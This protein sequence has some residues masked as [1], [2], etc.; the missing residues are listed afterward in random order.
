MRQHRCRHILSEVALSTRNE[1]LFLFLVKS[2]LGDVG[3]V[4]ECAEA[5]HQASYMTKT[6]RL[7][8]EHG[9][10]DLW[11]RKSRHGQQLVQPFCDGN[12]LRVQAT[13]VLLKMSRPTVDVL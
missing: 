3:W 13:K 10:S 8:P 9:C 1:T 4:T 7:H 2:I 6:G 5:R 12:G 11:S